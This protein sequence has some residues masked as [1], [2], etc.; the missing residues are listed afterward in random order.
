MMENWR[1]DL[2][3]FNRTQGAMAVEKCFFVKLT[4]WVGVRLKLGVGSAPEVKCN[5]SRV[6][7][8]PIPP[9]DPAFVWSRQCR[10]LRNHRPKKV[11]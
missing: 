9:K 7:I 2:R 10:Q 11:L 1:R 3:D 8:G 5:T 4:D 6:G